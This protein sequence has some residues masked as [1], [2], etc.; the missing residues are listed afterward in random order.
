MLSQYEHLD[1]EGFDD[2]VR[3]SSDSDSSA[4]S[5]I[6]PIRKHVRRLTSDEQMLFLLIINY[7]SN[8]TI[9]FYVN[10]SS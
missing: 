1:E 3:V 9:S 4:D 10:P 2:K 8:K 6:A 5:D 7:L